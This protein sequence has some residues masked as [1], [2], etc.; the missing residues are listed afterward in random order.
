MNVDVQASYASNCNSYINAWIQ[1]LSASCTYYDTAELRIKVIPQLKAICMAGSDKNHLLG[2]SSSSTPS[3]DNSF[4]KVLAAY[5]KEKGIT[6]NVNCNGLLITAPGAYDKQ[7]ANYDEVTYSKPT[8]CECEKLRVL[9]VEYKAFRRTT[10]TSLTVY[11]N[12]T[13]GTSLTESQ[14]TYQLTRHLIL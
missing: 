3:G 1:Q 4:Q 9:N 6:D 8:D 14:V 7:R 10:D 5:D 2:S 13:R 12:R 11:L